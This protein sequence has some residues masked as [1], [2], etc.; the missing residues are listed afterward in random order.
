MAGQILLHASR[1]GFTA[2]LGGG[3][4]HPEHTTRAI[5]LG[6]LAG[7]LWIIWEAVRSTLPALLVILEPTVGI[8][9]LAGRCLFCGTAIGL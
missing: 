5:V 4:P 6:L 7:V 9:R 3:Q 2:K 8:L 1:S